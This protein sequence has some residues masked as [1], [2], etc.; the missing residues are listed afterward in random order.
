M[1]LPAAQQLVA[2]VQATPYRKF[3]SPGSELGELTT[4]HAAPFH[5]KMSVWKTLPLSKYPTAEH[6]E[7]EPHA[8][9]FSVLS[10]KVEVFGEAMTVQVDPF[11]NSVN[12]CV[13]PLTDSA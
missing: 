10:F 4:A 13:T 1:K 7:L 12:V 3:C 2:L 6:S 11:H 9:L 5:L 8:T